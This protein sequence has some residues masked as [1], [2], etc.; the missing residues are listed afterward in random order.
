M[1]WTLVVVAERRPALALQG[2]GRAM[3]TPPW[4]GMALVLAQVL[5]LALVATLAQRALVL[6]PGTLQQWRLRLRPCPVVGRCRWSR[7]QWRG[8]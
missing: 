1:R 8:R 6:T 5:A 3:A 4:V 2:Q 7:V